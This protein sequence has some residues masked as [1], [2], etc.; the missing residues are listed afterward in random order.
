[1]PGRLGPRCKDWD[2]LGSQQ[3]RKES[4]RVY[5]ELKKT[6][7]ARNVEPVQLV[8]NLLHRYFLY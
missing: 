5:D 3:K 8:G 6:S 7:E 2:K 4:Q 1:M